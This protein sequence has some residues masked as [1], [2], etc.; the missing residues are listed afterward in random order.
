[1]TPAEIA[2]K[3]YELSVEYGR[4]SEQLEAILLRKADTW[5]AL[6]V[7]TKSDTA[8]DRVWDATEDGKEELRLVMTMKRNQRESSALS[9]LLR[10]KENEARGVW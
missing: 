5:R 10:V 8:A 7:D 3:R 6:R 9:S 2:N 1:M 4:L